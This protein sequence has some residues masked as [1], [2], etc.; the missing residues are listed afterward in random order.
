MTAMSGVLQVVD[1]SKEY[2]TARGPL[3]VLTGVG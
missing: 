3:R 1:L 2:P